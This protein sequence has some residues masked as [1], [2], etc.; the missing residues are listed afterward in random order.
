MIAPG[1]ALCHAPLVNELQCPI[2]HASVL[3][4]NFIQY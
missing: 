2:L 3:G 4:G 1:P